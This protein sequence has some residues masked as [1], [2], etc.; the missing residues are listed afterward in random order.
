M[1]IH[2]RETETGRQRARVWRH[3]YNYSGAFTC[4]RDSVPTYHM[5]ERVR[6]SCPASVREPG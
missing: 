5:L 2:H 3:R 1:L 6:A 4:E